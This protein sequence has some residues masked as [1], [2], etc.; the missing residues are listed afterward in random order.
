VASASRKSSIF[1]KGSFFWRVGVG[2][3]GQLGNGRAR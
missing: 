3:G 2:N 1:L